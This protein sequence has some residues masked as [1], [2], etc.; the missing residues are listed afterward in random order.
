MNYQY[1]KY[2]NIYFKESP[3]AFSLFLSH[4]Y[5][6]GV[7]FLNWPRFFKRIFYS[8]RRFFLS[9]LFFLKLRRL[10]FQKVFLAED[11]IIK[12]E[13]YGGRFGSDAILM[14]NQDREGGFCIKKVFYSADAYW[15]YKD[16]YLRYRQNRTKICLPLNDFNDGSMSATAEFIVSKSLARLIIEGEMNIKTVLTHISEI[17]RQIGQLDESEEKC[18]VHG[19][20][21]AANIFFQDG[22]YYLIDYA[23]SFEYKK[24]Y[25]EYFLIKSILKYAGAKN[26]GYE[27]INKF[28]T[29]SQA[30]FKEYE[31]VYQARRREK[32]K[33]LSD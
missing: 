23:D 5:E 10:I 3:E 7:R 15:A 12:K 2:K 28:L 27:S 24:K 17:C 31:T 1:L 20:F 16:Y 13:S 33:E 14:E 19:D 6:P 22:R 30:E 26:P 11:F 9:G 4:F 21:S 8:S 25:D 18:L 32:K 29:L